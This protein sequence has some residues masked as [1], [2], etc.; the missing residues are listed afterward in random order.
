MPVRFFPQPSNLPN[1][2]IPG[3]NLESC[4][5]IYSKITKQLLLHMRQAPQV[6][7]NVSRQGRHL[8]HNKHR[9]PCVLPGEGQNSLIQRMERLIQPGSKM[10]SSPPACLLSWSGFDY[11][12]WHHI[13]TWERICNRPR[14]GSAHC[15]LLHWGLWV[16]SL[17]LDVLPSGFY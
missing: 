8:G 15:T 3:D 7:L 6:L 1:L 16:H 12:A 17:I 14:Q 9:S 13:T 5:Y 11:S 10:I 4:N 2:W